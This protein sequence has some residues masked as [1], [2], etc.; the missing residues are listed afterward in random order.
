MNQATVEFRHVSKTYGPQGAVVDLSLLVPAGDICVLVGPSGCGKTTSLKMVNRLVEPSS[1]Q[2]LIDGVDI[3][4]IEVTA[5][6]RR[7]GYVIQQIG[8]FPHQTVA[9]NIATVPRLLGWPKARV[10]ARVDELL[11]LIGLDPARVRDRYPAQLSGG[12]RQ[13]VGVARAMAAEPPV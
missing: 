1:G 12:E 2:V 9:D 8:L 6:R 13:R 4:T 3:M 10:R 7:I 5:L 11:E